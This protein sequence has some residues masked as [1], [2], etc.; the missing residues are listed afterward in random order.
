[1]VLEKWS[2]EGDGAGGAGAFAFDVAGGGPVVGSRYVLC[3]LYTKS[4]IRKY[5]IDTLHIYSYGEG[6]AAVIK[7]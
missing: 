4:A 6:N 2:V 1:M 7:A 3:V 5:T